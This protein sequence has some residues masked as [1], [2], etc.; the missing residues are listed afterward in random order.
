MPAT[1]G[2]QVANNRDHHPHAVHQQWQPLPQLP[3]AH[4]VCRLA[5]FPPLCAWLDPDDLT[6]DQAWTCAAAPLQAPFPC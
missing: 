5:S 2:A 1:G 3:D 4:H 6:T